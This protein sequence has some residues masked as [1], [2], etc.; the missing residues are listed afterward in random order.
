MPEEERFEEL[1]ATFLKQNPFAAKA[2]ETNSKFS[3][4][5]SDSVYLAIMAVA[6]ELWM[7]QEAQ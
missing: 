5:E 3:Q 7:N 1:K 4:R 6:F 2:V